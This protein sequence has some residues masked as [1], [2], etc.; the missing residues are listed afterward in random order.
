M[1]KSEEKNIAKG[2]KWYSLYAIYIKGFFNEYS[3]YFLHWLYN[4]FYKNE[5]NSSS[6]YK[7]KNTRERFLEKVTSF[8]Y[9]KDSAILS[10]IFFF[11][12]SPFF[13][14]F[15]PNNVLKEWHWSGIKLRLTCSFFDFFFLEHET[16]LDYSFL[17]YRLLV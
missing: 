1:K 14:S 8:A 7:L 13:Y 10:F 3:S 5:N 16:Q 6:N 15:H 12:F 9:T 11:F 4:N 2:K 17:L